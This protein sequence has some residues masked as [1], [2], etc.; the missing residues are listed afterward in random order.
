MFWDL[1]NLFI[2]CGYK[3]GDFCQNVG[4]FFI[5]TPS[6]TDSRSLQTAE[7]ATV[8]KTKNVFASSGVRQLFL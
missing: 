5:R 4:D 2:Y 3:F 8:T 7:E 1:K 6:H